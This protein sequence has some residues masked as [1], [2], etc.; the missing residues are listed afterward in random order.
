M[1]EESEK[2]VEVSTA[3]Q[4]FS[5]FG[6]IIRLRSFSPRCKYAARGGFSLQLFRA[7]LRMSVFAK[8]TAG[9]S[10]DS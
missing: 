6:Q 7:S 5:L 1:N 4:G 10:L 3:A 2:C 8:H 9:G